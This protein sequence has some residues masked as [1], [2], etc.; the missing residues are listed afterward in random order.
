MYVKLRSAVETFKKRGH[1]LC[2]PSVN[3]IVSDKTKMAEAVMKKCNHF[4]SGYCK[5]SKSKNGCRFKHPVETCQKLNCS[6]TNF[7][8]RHPKKCKYEDKCMYQTM[9]SYKH[10]EKVTTHKTEMDVLMHIIDN[11]KAEIAS[12][13][14]ENNIKI[15][16]LVKVHMRELNEQKD[17]TENNQ[18]IFNKALAAKDDE[19]C[20]SLIVNIESMKDITK[21]KEENRNLQTKIE[22]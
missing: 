3:F 12:L 13:K 6:I 4:N 11:L 21:L 17:M 18:D 16:I 14:E 22:I 20:K 8:E 15:N 2:A 10:K 1:Q 7:P 5:F 9:C 19:L